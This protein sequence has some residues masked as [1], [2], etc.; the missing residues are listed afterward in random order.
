[1]KRSGLA[2]SPFFKAPELE[3]TSP[4]LKPEGGNVK[5]STEEDLRS[6]SPTPEKMGTP[7]MQG[8][9]YEIQAQ[10]RTNDRTNERSNVKFNKPKRVKIRHTF[11][12]YKDQLI[13]LQVIQLEK[14]KRG[15]KK[16]KLGK[17]VSK[18]I[19]LYIKKAEIKKE[20]A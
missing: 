19:D 7:A 3:D 20:H 4:S 15:R 18:G 5:I 11:D 17:M 10:N 13:S 2:D 6:A 14:V 9:T 16:P 1:M 8:Q 12:I